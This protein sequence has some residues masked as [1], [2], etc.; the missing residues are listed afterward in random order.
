MTRIIEGDSDQYT[1][2]FANTTVFMAFVLQGIQGKTA[3][4]TSPPQ[5]GILA[6]FAN[7]KL[8]AKVGTAETQ[9][10]AFDALLTALNLSTDAN[11]VL[12]FTETDT[13]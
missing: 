2:D 11:F 6:S 5:W 13:N 9:R 8:T 10:A 4:E 1:A 12:P 7:G 3:E